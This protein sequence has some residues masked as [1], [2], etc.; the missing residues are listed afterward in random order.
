MVVTI[1]LILR[2]WLMLPAAATN[3]IV[4]A[5]I[6][7]LARH[8]G[9]T[10]LPD[11]L[12]LPD[13]TKLPL[14]DG[15]TK[16]A[17][18][19][20]EHPDVADMFAQRYQP[21]PIAPVTVADWDPGRVRLDLLLRAAYPKRGIIRIDF[22]GHKALV[23]ERAAPAFA[24]VAARLQKAQAAD[25]ELRPFLAKLGGTLNERNIAGTDRP[26]AHS[27]GIAIDINPALSNYWR[28]EKSGWSNQIPQAIV[29]AF[30]AEGFIWGGRWSHFDTMHFEYR[31][32]LLD[33]TCFDASAR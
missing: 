19:R 17:D 2:G 9:M 29:D 15:K 30:E 28:W 21:G 25:P 1:S 6:A 13:G 4:P 32:E 5:P 33:P 12:Q 11:A 18:E 23:H 31:P 3:A 7:C 20:L 16:T 24:R 14:H 26:S 10:A 27:W 8:Y 22:L